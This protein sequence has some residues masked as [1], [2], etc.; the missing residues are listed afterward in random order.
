MLLLNGGFEDGLTGWYVGN[1]GGS[2][3]WGIQSYGSLGYEPEGSG[4]EYAVCY[5]VGDEAYRDTLVSPAVPTGGY[6]S[7]KL[8]FTYAFNRKSYISSDYGKVLVRYHDGSSWGAW[9]E[10]KTYSTTLK[11]TDT[12]VLSP[13]Y[14][15]VQV[16]F[17]YVSDEGAYWFAVDDVRILGLGLLPHDVEATAILVPEDLHYRGEYISP[18]VQVSNRGTTD[19][20]VSVSLYILHSGDTLYR[21]YDSFIT[22]AGETYEVPFGWFVPESLGTYEAVLVVNGGTDDYHGNDTLRK[23]FKVWP[24]PSVVFGIPYAP[25]ITLDGRADPGEWTSAYRLDVS[26]YFGQSSPPTDTGVAVAY[27]QHDGSHLNLLVITGDTTYDSTDALY[28]FLDDD[29]DRTWES[30]EGLNLIGGRPYSVWATKDSGQSYV[31]PRKDLAVNVARLGDTFEV[32]VPMGVGLPPDPGR[33]STRVGEHF[34]AFLAYRDGR[35]GRFLAWWPQVADLSVDSL[36]PTETYLVLLRP[37]PW[38][39]VG[40]GLLPQEGCMALKVCTTS[41]VIYD[42]LSTAM[43]VETL[44]V[45]VTKGGSPVLYATVPI[46]A[47]YGSVDTLRFRWMPPDSGYYEVAVRLTPNGSRGNDTAR[48]HVPVGK[49]VLPPYVQDFDGRWPPVGWKVSGR[50]WVHG[51][52]IG[53]A[54]VSPT[55]GISN[56]HFAEFVS[57]ILPSGDSSILYLP[58]LLTPFPSHLGMYV[59]NGPTWSGRGNYD[60]I[61]LYYRTPGNPVWYPLGSV[62][63]DIPAWSYRTF[64]LPPAETLYVK[65]V[66]RSDYGDTDLSV[67]NLSVLPGL[68]VEEAKRGGRECRYDGRGIVAEEGSEVTVYSADGR[69]VLTTKV[70]AEGRVKLPTEA[71]VYFVLCNGVVIKA[72]SPL[73]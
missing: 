37:D 14:D 29:G 66:A 73:K 15:S 40:V 52:Y 23:T 60:R 59:W 5:A 17:A 51:H 2:S 71:G 45:S 62:F 19:V 31:F 35:S 47:V 46:D 39:D 22:S 27:L 63:G 61:D 20:S 30:G 48:A 18:L 55:F 57:F 26:N 65:I 53:D 50:G 70:G 25:P 1:G 4:S 10:V 9:Y 36:K 28:L 12:V 44:V 13:G 69:M 68:A 64:N 58:P 8:T 7:L 3:T 41:V 67:D 11:G 38:H 34:S 33:L 49:V 43:A 54:R 56:E 72:V 16:A 42:N 21:G 32:S 24:Y 6:D